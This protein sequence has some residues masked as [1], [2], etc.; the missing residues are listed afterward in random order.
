MMWKYEYDYKDIPTFL[1][2]KQVVQKLIKEDTHK[3]QI[4]KNEQQ[5]LRLIE[6]VSML[7]EMFPEK[8][9]QEIIKTLSLD[10]WLLQE[11][12]L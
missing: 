1:T 3:G 12:E 9:Q 7:V 2:T 5:L 10:S 6:L 11:D 8:Q 4:E